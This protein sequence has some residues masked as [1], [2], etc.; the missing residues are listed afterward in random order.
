L[1]A[2]RSATA[3][4]HTLLDSNLRIG[5]A[6]AG[7]AD[8]AT[9]I[10]LLAAWLQALEPHLNALNAG[11]LGFDFSPSSRRQALQA[12]LQDLQ[13]FQH[14]QGPTAQPHGAAPGTGAAPSVAA[15]HQAALALA[16]HPTQADAVRWGF[17]YVV[18][19]SQLGGQVLYRQLA[20]RLAPHPL[21]YLQGDG[22]G[23]AARWR[24]FVAMLREQVASPAAVQAACDGAVAAFKGLMSP[25]FDAKGMPQ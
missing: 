25:V 7:V 16:L 19:G 12:D 15:S 13:H 17:A 14:L 22:A 2:L 24:Q 6:D 23:T 8:Y 9:H 20:H 5:Q 1:Q 4:L 18:E 11:G 10:T 21:R 3:A